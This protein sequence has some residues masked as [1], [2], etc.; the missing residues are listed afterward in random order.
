MLKERLLSGRPRTIPDWGEHLHPH[1]ADDGFVPWPAP[2]L[3]KE[4]IEQRLL[5]AAERG[6]E[7]DV[8]LCARRNARLQVAARHLFATWPG[9]R[10]RVKALHSPGGDPLTWRCLAIALEMFGEGAQRLWSRGQRNTRP[11]PKPLLRS[12]AERQEAEQSVPLA[13]LRETLDLYWQWVAAPDPVREIWP[14]IRDIQ[15]TRIADRHHVASHVPWMW[16]PEMYQAMRV[17]LGA[18]ICE[19]LYAANQAGQ[20]LIEW[21]LHH[22]A[23]HHRATGGVR[24][25]Y[26]FSDVVINQLVTLAAR[27]D[28]AFGNAPADD[29]GWLYFV[30]ELSRRA[31]A[32]IAIEFKFHLIIK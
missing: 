3:T 7:A 16:V 22:R 4:E 25:P 24:G 10:Q 28:A 26:G 15:L 30:N 23:A 5:P 12:E 9:F 1:R 18:A 29:S 6:R 32:R 19:F 31:R 21:M 14:R 2:T 27:W 20:M 17:S 8:I 13:M 11:S